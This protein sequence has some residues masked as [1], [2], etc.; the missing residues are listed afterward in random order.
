MLWAIVVGSFDFAKRRIPNELSLGIAL[1]ALLF[2]FFSGSSL[3]GADWSDIG[4][5][6]LLGLLLTLPAYL[7]RWL[8]AGDVK[9]MLA[10]ACVGGLSAVVL[11]FVVAGLLAGMTALIVTQGLPHAGM[12]QPRRWLPFGSALAA[13]IV[14]VTLS[15]WRL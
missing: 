13:G 14:A 12:M 4:L 3:L 9:L 2:F 5:G 11:S 7:M 1:V 10:I 8:G 6:I 15:G